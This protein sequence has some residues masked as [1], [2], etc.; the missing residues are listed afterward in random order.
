MATLFGQTLQCSR[1]RSI[2]ISDWV[3]VGLSARPF[4][5]SPPLAVF[6]LPLGG[7][8][9]FSAHYPFSP[10]PLRSGSPG[11]CSCLGVG[12]P[13]YWRLV[14]RGV[15]LLCVL[16]CFGWSLLVVRLFIIFFSS[17]Y[18]GSVVA[19]CARLDHTLDWF[20]LM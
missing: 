8:L 13:S 10:S 17:L 5:A 7:L 2:G 1:A 20:S 9:R 3:R 16:V 12:W 4:S 15:W 19:Q 11:L 14:W 18:T 6:R